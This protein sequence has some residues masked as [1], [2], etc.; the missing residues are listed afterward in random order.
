MPV[1]LQ[2]NSTPERNL[3]KEGYLAKDRTEEL[4]AG[5]RQQIFVTTAV[6]DVTSA[7]RAGTEEIADVGARFQKIEEN[8]ETLEEQCNKEDEDIRCSIR[9][10][11]EGAEFYQTKA[12]V[13]RD[14]RLVYAPHEGVGVFGGEIDNW[15][16]PRH[17]G[18]FT[19]L[20]AYVGPDGKPADYSP[21]NVPFSPAHHLKVASTPLREGDLVMVA[22][23]PGRTNRLATADLATFMTETYYP[24]AVERYEQRIA[25]L[26]ALA[27]DDE[28]LAIKVNRRLRGWNNGLTNNRGMLDG[29]SKG[30]LVKVKAESK[31]STS[32]AVVLSSMK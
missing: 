3:L 27:A 28:E 24:Y 19:F 21:D 9:S 20:R 14:V 30:G 8:I 23:Y 15:R 2:Y 18:D 29:L 22:G 4:W 31:K 13:I 1:A 25:V 10:F 7:V 11:F 6:E 12:M 32:V 26:E 16:W 5:P 17:T